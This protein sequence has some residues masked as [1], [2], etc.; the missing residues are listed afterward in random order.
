MGH[1]IYVF[2]FG[3]SKNN[4]KTLIILTVFLTIS[5]NSFGGLFKKTA[6]PAPAPSYVTKAQLDAATNK[7][8]ND[9]QTG[10]LTPPFAPQAGI[11]TYSILIDP[12]NTNKLLHRNGDE[13]LEGNIN[14]NDNTMSN[15]NFEGRFD[16][17]HF[18]IFDGIHKGNGVN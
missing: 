13:I 9:V 1:P 5:V 8:G 16:G 18:G 14:V 12:N 11:A 3:D 15:G 6:A 10:K 17:Q 4:M 7:V 2:Q